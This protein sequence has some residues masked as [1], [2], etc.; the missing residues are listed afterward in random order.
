MI[1]LIF[2]Q[3][4]DAKIFTAIAA[5]YS[6]LFALTSDGKLAQWDWNADEPFVDEV[7]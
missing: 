3:E 1:T 4:K 2:L 5:T 6:H 7:S